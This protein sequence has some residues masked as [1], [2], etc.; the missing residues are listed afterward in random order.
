MTIRSIM[1]AAASVTLMMTGGAMAANYAGGVIKSVTVGGHEMLT[2]GQGRTLYV[3][4]QDGPGVSNCNGLCRLAWP[5]QRAAN[6]AKASGNFAPVEANGGP[7][8]AFKG[9][10]LY[11]FSGDHKA[12][13]V[14]GDGAEGIW[15]AA[16]VR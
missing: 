7:I 10:P 8:W 11:R 3:Y 15:H 6:G 1:L 5:P 9:H 4:D 2:D 12:G 16:L 14:K 13:D